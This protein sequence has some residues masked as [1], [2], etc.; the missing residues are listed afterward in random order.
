MFAP[1]H[2]RTNITMKQIEA[3]MSLTVSAFGIG[4]F[5]VKTKL[6]SLYQRT[7]IRSATAIYELKTSR[8]CIRH[9]GILSTSSDN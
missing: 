6:S 5:S 1:N 3:E 7:R 8:C 2:R 9:E 4:F